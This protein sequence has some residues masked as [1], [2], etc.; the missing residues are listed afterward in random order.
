MKSEFSGSEFLRNKYP[1]IEESKEVQR[2]INKDKSVYTDA[3]Q[4]Y[5]YR[6]ETILNTK[7]YDDKKTGADLLNSFIVRDFTIDVENEENILRLARS[8]YESERNQAINQGRGGEIEN[9][10]FSDAQIIKRYKQAIKE[11]HEVQKNTLANWLNYLKTSNDYPLWF[12]YYVVRGLKDMGSFD[13]DDKKYA[14]RTFD[15]IAPFP[16]RNSESL[17][18]VKKSLELQL[19]V[20]T[21]E[22]PPEIE[23]DIVS[24]TKLD[25][26]TIQKIQENSK[27]EYIELAQK[28]ALKNLRNKKR[29]EYVHSIKVQ[30]IKDF[31]REYNLKEDREDELVEEFEKRL[32]SKDFAQL[33]AFAQVEAAGSLDR[34]SLDGTWVKYDQG[35]DY[36]PLEN[37]LRGKGT[38]WCTAEG[39]AEGQLESG[40]FYVYY[41]KNTATDQYTEPRIAIRMQGG[42]IAEIRGVDKQQELEPQLVD[43]AKEKYK[44]LPGAQKYEK[45]DH[46][47]RK[48]TDIY[49]RSFYKDKDTKV[50]TYLSPDL[51]KE[52]LIFLYEIES[53]IKTFGYDTD[54][55]VQ[56]VKQERDK[57]NDYT[58][59][60]DCEPYQIVQD[61]KDVT[62]DT[63]VYIGDLDPIDYKILDKR[64]NPIVIDGNTNFKDCTSL[65]TIPEG[66]VFNG[67]A[68]FEN[69]TSL[70]TIPI[71]IVFHGYANFFGCTS[72]TTIP[73]GIVFHGGASFSGCTSL[74]TIPE[75]T[76]FNGKADFFG[77]TSLTTIPEG[78][79]FNGV[80]NFSGCTSLTTIPEGTVFN[81]NAYFENCTSLTTIPEGTVFNGKADF[82]GCTSLTEKTKE[83]LY[84]M[85]NSGLIKGELYI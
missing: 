44:N 41:T 83:M 4:T 20:E 78:T 77:C 47:M 32:N 15:T 37:S 14:N 58:T 68:D 61:V 31:L 3:V 34:E 19:E 69:C 7:R 10:D 24:N 29:Q 55:R 73:E 12:K 79:V 16:E 67:D 9:I 45:A 63:K 57:I 71:G 17:G 8:F 26:D 39:S 49:S 76:V 65:T 60:Y 25:N 6:I 27:P 59:L 35:S 52:E 28:G 80:A 56:E 38:G 51:T 84:N 66:T 40:D 74:T 30:K 1:K 2:A 36:T 82:S 21:I 13:R 50:K 81:G 23:E 75:G 11:K 18:F 42:Q 62:E 85:K 43:I 54:P 46:D 70:T 5:L 22:I 48:M 72:L 33:Y 64:T 53:K